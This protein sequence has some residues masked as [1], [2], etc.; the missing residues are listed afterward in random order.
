MQPQQFHR[1]SFLKQVSSNPQYD[2][3]IIGGGATGLGIAV[4]GAARGLKTIL[5]EQHDFAKGTSSR[6]T[7]LVHGGVR[8]LAMGDVKL[9]HEALRER[10]ILF[11]N[12]PHLAHSQPFVIPCYSVF[13]KWK[14]LIGLKLYDWLAGSRR[15]GNSTFVSKEEVRKNFPLLKPDRLKG[16]VRYFDGQFDDSRLAINLAQTAAAFGAA[17]INYCRVTNLLKSDNGRINGIRF[18]DMETGTSHELKAKMVVNATG[19]FVDDIL[20]MDT[21]DHKPIV[22]PSQGTHIVIDRSFIGGNEALMIPKTSDGRVL[23][24]VP[25]HNHLVIGTTDIPVD[26]HALEPKPTDKEIDFILETAANYLTKAPKKEDVLSVFAGLRPL[27][28]PANESGATKEISRSHKLIVS[29][30]GLITITGGKWTTYRKM[31]EDT[32]NKALEIGGIQPIPCQTASLKIHG[33]THEQPS[34]HWE[35]YGSDAPKIQQLARTNPA[36]QE[37][38]HANFE[39]LVAEVIWATRHEMARTVEDVLARRLRILFLDVSAAIEMAPKVAEVMAGELGN[40]GDWI[41]SQLTQFRETALAY[42][43][44]K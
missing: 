14:Y 34:G 1:I 37:K 25:W 27:A 38:L 32:V 12:A 42:Q 35:V 18:I 5:L 15:I 28:A 33:H 29:S 41:A 36:W 30:S 13:S 31:A 23:F 44:K 3:A 20:A 17:V 9:V 26:H 22:K 2:L 4:D 11:A 43:L 39:H 21:G 40:D 7:K 24:G 10:G 6:S 16:G 8:Y 19:V